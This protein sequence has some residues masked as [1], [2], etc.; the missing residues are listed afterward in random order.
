M[1]F[2]YDQNNSGGSFTLNEN[3]GV[4]VWIEARNAA[5]ADG[6][7]QSIGIYFDENYSTDC[8]C[9]GTRWSPRNSYWASDGVE[10]LEEATEY[11]RSGRYGCWDGERAGVAHHQD[12]RI[13]NVMFD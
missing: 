8:E 7:A 10:T 3:L 5:E 13:E 12:G 1:W 2:E 11:A 9:C 4:K 6:Y